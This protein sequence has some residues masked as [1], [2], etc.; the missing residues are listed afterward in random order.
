VASLTVVGSITWSKLMMMGIPRM[1]SVSRLLGSTLTTTGGDIGLGLSWG[2]DFFF[3]DCA[4]TTDLVGLGQLVVEVD[5]SCL[6]YFSFELL[7]F[8][9]VLGIA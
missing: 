7:L 6:L 1:T 2:D 3:G 5:G 4:E 9:L 8:G